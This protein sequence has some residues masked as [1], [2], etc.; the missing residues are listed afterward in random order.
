MPFFEPALRERISQGDIFSF[1][2]CATIKT[3]VDVLS[4]SEYIRGKRRAYPYTTWDETSALDEVKGTSTL[5]ATRAILLTHDCEVDNDV[6]YRLVAPLRVLGQLPAA[7]QEGVR[8]NRDYRFFHI[9]PNGGE[10]EAYVD[11]RRLTTVA[12]ALIPEQKRLASISDE[13]KKAL[14]LALLLFFTRRVIGM[15]GV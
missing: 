8:E 15:N 4:T 2:P 3:P 13:A 10:P 11:F 6:R 7:T 9:P 5:S 1:T 12:P 14:C